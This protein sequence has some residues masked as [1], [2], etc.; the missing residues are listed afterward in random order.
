MNIGFDSKRAFHNSRG[1]GNYSKDLISGLSRSSAKNNYFLFTPPIKNEENKRWLQGHEDLTVVTPN[2]LFSKKIGPLWRS[3][4]ITKEFKKYNI[5]LYH[6]LSHELPFGIG[7]TQVKTALTVHDLIFMRFPEYFP[8]I[9]RKIYLKKLTY[10][11]DVANVIIAICEQTKNDLVEMLNIDK[12]KI[13]VA[14]QSCNPRFYT[15]LEEE[16]KEFILKRYNVS[17]DFILIVGAIEPRKNTLTLL[18]AF[19]NLKDSCQQNLII[20]GDGGKY[21][22]RIEHFIKKHSLEKRVRILSNVLNIDLPAFYQAATL[23]CY[24]SF[25][26]GF[27][28]PIIESLFSE[29]PVITS[30]GGVFPEVAGENSLYIDP[31]STEELTEKIKEVINSKEIQFNMASKGRIFVEKFHRIKTTEKIIQIYQDISI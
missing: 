10:S 13:K 23:F 20:I 29:T 9:D 4:F 15:A 25:F 14:Y 5:D 30:K 18:K 6:G 22:K 24:P 12:N 21:K 2:D 16:K 31:N 28:I 3:F 17:K 8:W 7:K 1:L 19:L 27:G 26:E 11:C